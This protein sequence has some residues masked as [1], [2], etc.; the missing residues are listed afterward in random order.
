MGVIIT[1]VKITPNPVK[2]GEKYTV[3]VTVKETVQEPV[4]PITCGLKG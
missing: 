2:V 1:A 3:E 4:W